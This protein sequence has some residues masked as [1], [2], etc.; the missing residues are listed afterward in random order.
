MYIIYIYI[1]IYIYNKENTII[2]PGV[3][4]FDAMDE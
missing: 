1:Y 4:R 2:I 3:D